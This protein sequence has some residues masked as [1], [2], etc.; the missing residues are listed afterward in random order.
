MTAEETV[1]CV[2]SLVS[3]DVM[4]HRRKQVLW[5]HAEGWTNS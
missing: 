2:V 1:K 4:W 5:R 3:D